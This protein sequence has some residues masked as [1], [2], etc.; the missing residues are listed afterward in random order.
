MAN[1]ARDGAEYLPGKVAILSQRMRQNPVI[2]KDLRGRMR[3][4]RAYLVVTGYLFLLSIA[5]GILLLIFLATGE[6][7][8]S[9][10]LRQTLGKSIFGLVVG[11][12]LLTMCFIAPALTAGA[13]SSER[14]QQTFDLL[15]TTLL[16]ARFLVTGKLLAAIFF[17]WLLLFSALP[18]QSL[19]FLFGGVALDEILIATL[20]L[21]I[22]AF[23][24]SAI[25]LFFSSLVRRTLISTVLSYG[26]ALIL[27]FGIPI[28]LLLSISLYDT[29][30]YSSFSPPSITFQGVL[31]AIAWILVS[32]N[33]LATV[34][35]TELILVEEQ[36]LFYFVVPLANGQYFYFLSPWISYV[37]IYFIV[38]LILIWISVRLV[39]RVER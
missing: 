26:T 5:V 19:A 25:G 13:I 8:P 22:T 16:R 1:E 35:I 2:L 30:Y 23:A 37:I 10:N 18:L 11:I 33:P 3:G 21:L 32:L 31:L 7:T 14:E 38:G 39:Q 27:V 20:T 15:R 9:I 6:T 24:F 4:G 34:V 12:Q 17:L 28:V 36:S 29:F